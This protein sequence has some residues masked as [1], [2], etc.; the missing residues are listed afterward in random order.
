M[1]NRSDLGFGEFARL[2]DMVPQFEHLITRK[3]LERRLVAGEVP[4]ARKGPD[5]HWV[6]HVAT[7]VAWATGRD[8]PLE[9]RPAHQSPAG[10]PEVRAATP[11]SRRFERLV[12]ER[13]GHG[14]TWWRMQDTI[15]DRDPVEFIRDYVR[16][17]VGHGSLQAEG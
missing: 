10:P 15:D 2:K 16:F 4:S 13:E 5:G 17:Q 12:E 6:V 3:T 14:N 7:I 9:P 11:A 1:T 8:L